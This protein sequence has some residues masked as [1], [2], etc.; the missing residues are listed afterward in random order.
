MASEESDHNLNR[1]YLYAHGNPYSSVVEVE[2]DCWL[3]IATIILLVNVEFLSLPINLLQQIRC[4]L[5]TK[6]RI[7]PMFMESICDVMRDLRA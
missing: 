2:N 5:V 1:N 4:P 6:R 7:L 3:N